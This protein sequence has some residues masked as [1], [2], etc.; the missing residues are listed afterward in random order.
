VLFKFVL[1]LTF[2]V[3]FFNLVSTLVENTRSACAAESMLGEAAGD[4][5]SDEVTDEDDVSDG[6]DDDGDEEGDDD[7]PVNTDT[8]EFDVSDDDMDVFKLS[9]S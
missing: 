2:V 8:D 3:S 7:A 1:V 9:L 5:G 4:D 6:D